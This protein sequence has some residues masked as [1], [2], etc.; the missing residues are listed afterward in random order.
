M[1]TRRGIKYPYKD[2]PVITLHSIAVIYSKMRGKLSYPSISAH[3]FAT[4]IKSLILQLHGKLIT[5]QLPMVSY[6]VMK[7]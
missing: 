5:L 4:K 3:E 2:M 6:L 7:I 1:A